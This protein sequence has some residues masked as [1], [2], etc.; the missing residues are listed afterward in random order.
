MAEALSKLVR[1]IE[2]SGTQS[3]QGVYR[4]LSL[5]AKDTWALTSN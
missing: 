3:I 1:V 2:V 4:N 5:T